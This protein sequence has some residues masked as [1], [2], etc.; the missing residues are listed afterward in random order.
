M[1]W[2]RVGL[3]PAAGAAIDVFTLKKLL[4][5]AEAAVRAGLAAKRVALGELV[6][7]ASRIALL[8]RLTLFLS[9]GLAE[10]THPFAQ[11]L[12]RF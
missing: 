9:H 5:G 2:G 7:F 3:T 12:D 11:G 8:P 10:F 6:R 4:I 1:S